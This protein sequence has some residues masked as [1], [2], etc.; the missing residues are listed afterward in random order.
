LWV[1]IWEGKMIAWA[2]EAMN[3]QPDNKN[4]IMTYMILFLALIESA[5]IYWLVVGFQI[6]SDSTIDWY[7][8]LAAGLSIGLAWLWVGIWE[9]ILAQKALHV[10]SYDFKRAWYYLTVAIL[11]IALV[12]SAAIYGLIIAFQT[13]SL[14][15]VNALGIVGAWLAV[16]FA[17]LWVGIW[18]GKMVAWALEGMY[19]NPENR[20]KI[21]T[22]M[23]LFLALIE[24][25]AIYGLIT[26]FQI[27]TTEDVNALYSIWAW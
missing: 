27:I 7:L 26:S 3:K 18:E 14:E 11:G 15:N 12:E 2:F 10:I 8:A 25:A 17:G 4:K 1:G 20:W 23:I 21:L 6:L 16:W 24:S 9:W 19:K 5:A 13:L 22:F